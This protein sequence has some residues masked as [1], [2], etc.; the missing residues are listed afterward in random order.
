MK[1]AL[2][3]GTG[4]IGKVV[5]KKL[6]EAGH[7]VVALIRQGSLLKIAG[8]SGMESRYIYYDTPSQVK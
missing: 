2:A 3:G 6:V 7:R 4:F 1:V 8:F 5:I